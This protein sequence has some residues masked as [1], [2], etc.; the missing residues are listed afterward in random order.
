MLVNGH[1]RLGE[2]TRY[3]GRPGAETPRAHGHHGRA[4]GKQH[5]AANAAGVRRQ[6]GEQRSGVVRVAPGGAHV[7]VLA[8]AHHH[9][10]GRLRGKPS[11]E[12]QRSVVGVIARGGAILTEAGDQGVEPAR[13]EIELHADHVELALGLVGGE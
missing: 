4:R 6:Q 10:G 5:R 13:L 8:D 3:R 9:V 1:Q 12:G 11:L 2:W 7:T